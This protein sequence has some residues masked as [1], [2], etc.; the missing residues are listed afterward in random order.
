[1]RRI[2]KQKTY[3]VNLTKIRNNILLRLSITNLKNL[4]FVKIRTIKNFI[5]L[6]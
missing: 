5:L 3:L 1:M 4:K 6:C 2:V